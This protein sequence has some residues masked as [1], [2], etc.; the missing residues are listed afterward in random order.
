MKEIVE[1]IFRRCLFG[2]RSSFGHNGNGHLLIF[3]VVLF[4]LNRVRI[5]MRPRG[6]NPWRAR[7][8]RRSR[9]FLPQREKWRGMIGPD[10]SIAR[11]SSCDPGRRQQWRGPRDYTVTA[12]LAFEAHRNVRALKAHRCQGNLSRYS[13]RFS[14]GTG[15]G[16]PLLRLLI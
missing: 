8:T 9:H 13:G 12:A 11:S 3:G 15:T 14:T 5:C 6:H 10:Q 1:H 7:Y 4:F 16:S 2:V